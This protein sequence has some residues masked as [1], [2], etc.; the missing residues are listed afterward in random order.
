M[1]ASPLGN[2]HPGLT[3]AAL[4]HKPVTSGLLKETQARAQE[5]FR[6]GKNMKPFR[7]WILC[8]L[9]DLPGTIL[10]VSNR[11]SAGLRLK[12]RT[13]WVGRLGGPRA[14]FR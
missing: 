14:W 10:N 2:S 1:R 11:L 6:T 8:Q 5:T 9:T 3:L 7:L 12:S 4:R 13:E